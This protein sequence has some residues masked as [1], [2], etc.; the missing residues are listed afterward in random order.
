MLPMCYLES[1]WFARN[2]YLVRTESIAVDLPLLSMRLCLNAGLNC[3]ENLPNPPH[4]NAEDGA[5]E[6]AATAF[7]ASALGIAAASFL[8]EAYATDFRLG[9]YS[10]NPSELEPRLPSDTA[11][12]AWMAQA[13]A[14]VE[15]QKKIG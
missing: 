11:V 12:Q 5:H 3:F 1:C 6:Y 14:A 4:L 2:V 8:E 15:E 9:Q 10:R 13:I 7:W